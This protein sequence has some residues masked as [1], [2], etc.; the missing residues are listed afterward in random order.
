MEGV[1]WSIV[2]IWRDFGSLGGSFVSNLDVVT[3]NVPLLEVFTRLLFMERMS[4][5]A[6][7][8]PIGIQRQSPVVAS[9]C[10]LFYYY[11]FMYNK[12]LN[13]RCLYNLTSMNPCS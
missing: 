8:K 6:C 11:R 4:F 7:S 1:D 2:E 5:E 3:T 9:K 13:T 12:Y 10:M